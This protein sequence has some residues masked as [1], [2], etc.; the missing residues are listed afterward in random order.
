MKKIEHLLGNRGQFGGDIATAVADSNDHHALVLEAIGFLVRVSVQDFSFE[1]LL[2]FEAWP[3]RCAV[4]SGADHDA[5]IIVALRFVRIQIPDG[6]R[7]LAGGVVIVC[8]LHLDHFGSK[9][10]VLLQIELRHIVLEVLQLFERGL[11]KEVNKKISIMKRSA[12][13]KETF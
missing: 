2:V 13:Q 1:F 10:Q 3:Q 11:L 7:P 5:V 6:H 8:L 12:A 9:N 4:V